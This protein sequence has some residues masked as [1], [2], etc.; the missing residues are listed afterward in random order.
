MLALSIASFIPFSKIRLSILAI[1]IKF[2]LILD[3]LPAFIFSAKNSLDSCS[4]LLHF[5]IMNFF[6]PFLSSIITAEI[7]IF[8][9][10]YIKFKMLN[11]PPVSASI[12]NGL[13]VTSKI[14]FMLLSLLLISNAS[15]SGLPERLSQLESLTQNPSN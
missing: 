3:A 10:S 2:S 13:V 15:I 4:V 11:F 14:L 8:H 9:A 1:T 6:K 12:I 7:P 5:Q